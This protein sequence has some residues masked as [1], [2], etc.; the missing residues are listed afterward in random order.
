MRVRLVYER[1]RYV[2]MVKIRHSINYL[3][4]SLNLCFRCS[5]SWLR[6]QKTDF[7]Q[8]TFLNNLC[9]KSATLNLQ[10]TTFSKLLFLE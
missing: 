10:E 3:S 5:L 2:T 4:V 6:N 1:R 7:N 8:E 9:F